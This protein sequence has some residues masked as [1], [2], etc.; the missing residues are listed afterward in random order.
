MQYIIS[1]IFLALSSVRGNISRFDSVF[2]NRNHNFAEHMV[3][4]LL[5]VYYG[6]DPKFDVCIDAGLKTRGDSLS[7]LIELKK[8]FNAHSN[9][10]DKIL[11][12]GRPEPAQSDASLRE[13]A[14]IFFSPFKSHVQRT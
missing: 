9:N 6:M 1:C 12:R 4:V 13:L 7:Y 14:K 11:M 10:V 3:S 5:E 2:S 8:T